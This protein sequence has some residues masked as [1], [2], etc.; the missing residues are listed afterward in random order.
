[1]HG[2]R[3]VAGPGDAVFGL[4][5]GS[6]GSHVVAS[7][8]TVVPMPSSVRWVVACLICAYQVALDYSALLIRKCLAHF[9]TSTI[10]PTN[11]PPACPPPSLQL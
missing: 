9:S 11:N 6:L 2:T 3:V 8:H 4:A 10:S 5:M 1:M 7:S